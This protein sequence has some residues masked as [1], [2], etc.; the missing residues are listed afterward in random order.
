MRLLLVRHGQ[1]DWNLD[2]RYQGRVDVPLNGAGLEQAALLARDLAGRQIDLL[3]SS[4]LRRA[5]DTAGAIAEARGL[6]VRSDPRLREINLG[7]WEG[8]LST[9]IAEDY[10]KLFPRW[11]SDPG[12][13]RPPGGET[14]A[15][16]HDRVIP[17]LEELAVANPG[18]TVCVVVHKVVMVVVRC[19]YLGLDLREEMGRMPANGRWE[20]MEIFSKTR[21]RDCCSASTP[22]P[23]S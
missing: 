12:T 11:I 2:G 19:H 20:E 13:V 5:M 8:Q 18:R 15:E 3:I 16:V 22:V 6:E 23:L 14:I 21:L 17:A 4:P 1:T 9:K 7:E 10:P